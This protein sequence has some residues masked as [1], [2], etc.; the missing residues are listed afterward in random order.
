MGGVWGV[1]DPQIGSDLG[2]LGGLGGG[3]V[4]GLA[5]FCVVFRVRLGFLGIP[6]PP[7]KWGPG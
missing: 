3:R 7:E 4:D 2:F 5:S 6:D 1:G